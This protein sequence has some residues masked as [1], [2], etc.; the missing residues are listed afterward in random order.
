MALPSE[1][2]SLKAQLDSS[3]ITMGYQ[4]AIRFD[5]VNAADAHSEIYIDKEAMPP[6]IE[7]ID[8]VY[9]DT[10][11]LGNGLVEMKRTLVV[12]SFDS[13][14]YTIPPFMMI[15]GPDTIRSKE[16][17]LKVNP[18]DV[19]KKTDINPVAPAM[20][21]ET[22]WYDF[23]PDWLTDFFWVIL[24]V[25]LIIVA[26]ICGVLIYKKKLKIPFMPKAQ[27]IPPHELAMQ[28]LNALRESNMWQSGQEKEYYTSLI[29]ILRD[30]L[31]GRFG[32]NAMEMTSQQITH[33]LSQNEATRLPNARMKRI[34][35]IA[36]YV[37]FAKMR[38]MPDDN[39]RALIDAEQFVQETRPEPEPEADGK[40]AAPAANAQKP[41][42][43]QKTANAQKAANPQKPAGAQPSAA[44]AAQNHDN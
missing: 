43:P 29:D 14:V 35:E 8:W 17:T 44:E 24:A 27:P 28:R 32:I 31:Q 41:A 20:E 39:T 11:D 6:Q 7:V 30:Y 12:Q 34:L 9:G 22:R 23:L 19:S 25:V 15:A 40:P 3:Q 13:G 1:A 5:I 33:L 37:K 18:V 16:L 42:N 2:A 4:T 26:A 38:P 10:T 36:D 21:F